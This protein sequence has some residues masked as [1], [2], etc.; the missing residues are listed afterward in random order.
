V[1]KR[2][3]I[4]STPDMKKLDVETD[5]KAALMRRRADTGKPM[6][7]IADEMLRQ[8]LGLKPRPVSAA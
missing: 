4:P 8:G 2:R 7:R 6:W 3:V 5:V 1:K